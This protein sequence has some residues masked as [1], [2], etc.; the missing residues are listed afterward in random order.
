MNTNNLQTTGNSEQMVD[1]D[2]QTIAIK[3]LEPTV[4]VNK[5]KFLDALKEYA[6]Y[7]YIQNIIEYFDSYGEK[8]VTSDFSKVAYKL[9]EMINDQKPINEINQYVNVVKNTPLS[10]G[11]MRS[12]FG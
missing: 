7:L 6:E 5:K 4:K 12:F 11:E 8:A 1:N 2:Q 9:Y 3:I 10:Y